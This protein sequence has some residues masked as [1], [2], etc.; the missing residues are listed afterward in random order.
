M[1]MASFSAYTEHI[2]AA[3][4]MKKMHGKADG[5]GTTASKIAGAGSLELM[6]TA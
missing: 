5:T 2:V 6:K 4:A 1:R 3:F